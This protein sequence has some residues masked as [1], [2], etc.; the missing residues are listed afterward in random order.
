MSTTTPGF[1]TACTLP[2]MR[3]IESLDSCDWRATIHS[4][5][6]RK[7]L[8]PRRHTVSFLN[9]S[10]KKSSD[11]LLP[12]FIQI[13]QKCFEASLKGCASQRWLALGAQKGPQ[14]SQNWS[15][16]RQKIRFWVNTEFV[17]NWDEK[18]VLTQN[19]GSLG[20]LRA[21]KH[22]PALAFWTPGAWFSLSQ[23]LREAS[24]HF[25]EIWMKCESNLSLF[26]F[27]EQLRKLIFYNN[28]D[29]HNLFTF[30]ILSGWP[31]RYQYQTCKGLLK[32]LCVWSEVYPLLRKFLHLITLSHKI[33][34]L[35]HKIVQCHVT[36]FHIE[37]SHIRWRPKCF[38]GWAVWRLKSFWGLWWQQ[39]PIPT[40]TQVVSNQMKSNQGIS[41]VTQLTTSI[42][43]HY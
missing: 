13:S 36:Y 1:A 5:C 27:Q 26:F 40:K 31:C 41:E 29:F 3:F 30:N 25:W 22:P 32:P 43:G 28:W 38:L 6:A 39:Y 2:T 42:I 8:Q 35:I 21:R 33:V 4:R 16:T 12:H 11:K 15:F 17:H 18:W 37:P 20:A 24:K 23:R 10:W 19:M 9:C 14:N 34:R 7:D